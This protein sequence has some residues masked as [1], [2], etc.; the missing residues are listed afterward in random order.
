MR[1]EQ[2]SKTTFVIED[3]SERAIKIKDDERPRVVALTVEFCHGLPKQ[4]FVEVHEVIV[5]SI[6]MLERILGG[7]AGEASEGLQRPDGHFS[8]SHVANSFQVY[9]NLLDHTG[10]EGWQTL[11]RETE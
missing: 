2:I 1:R 5:G 9:G 11:E 3:L 8:H 7:E 6:A 10:D 4:S